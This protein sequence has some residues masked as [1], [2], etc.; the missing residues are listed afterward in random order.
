MR[1][2]QPDAL[3]A[4]RDRYP[5]GTR[6]EL[7]SMTDPY[8][9]LKPGDQGTVTF[10][11]DIG[12]VFVDWDS[13]SGLGV[14]FGEDHIRIVSELTDKV[15]EQIMDIRATGETNMF[16]ITRVQSMAFGK[17]FFELVLFLKEH[18]KRYAMFI[19]TGEKD[20]LPI[21]SFLK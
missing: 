17:G 18:P 15:V 4:L 8:S 7:I 21:T 12:T 9:K 3:T 11:D 10:V 13:G 1:M 20:T 5:A 16:D 14:A 2:I 19:M 6:V